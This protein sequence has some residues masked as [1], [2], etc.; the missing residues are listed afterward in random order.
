MTLRA[1]TAIPRAVIITFALLPLLAA[2]TQAPPPTPKRPVTDTY[3]GVKVV[4]DYRWL[5]NWNDPAVKD[6]VAAQNHY[7]RSY[8]DQLPGRDELRAKLKQINSAQSTSYRDV[9]YRGGTVFAIKSQPPKQQPFLVTFDSPDNA[10]SERVI[11]DPNK[12]DPSGGTSIDF[13]VPSLNGKQVAVA[14]S[15]GGSEKSDLHIFS[16]A[17]GAELPDVEPYVNGPTAG[18]GVAWKADGRG[19]YYTR[20]PRGNERPPADRDFYQQVWFHELGKPVEQDTYVLG[21]D[22]PRIAETQLHTSVDGAWVLVSTNN[23]DGGEQ[24]HFLIGASGQ[25]Q[26]ITHFNDMVRSA[27]LGEDGAVYL[28]SVRNAPR[29][30]I[31]RLSLANPQLA[32]AKEIVPES[33]A[34]IDQVV[35]TKSRLYVIDMVGGPSRVR[36]FDL[37]GKQ[38][39]A[40]RTLP[41]SA[42]YDVVPL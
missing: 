11:V 12:I 41:V 27:A 26:Q 20:Y 36:V 23:G 2:N 25:P 17:D 4:D 37:G 7:T 22:F 24:E 38:V 3:H 16:V 13:Y 29:G 35:P 1:F 28:R 30:K 9:I 40:I 18:G 32:N 21:R 19:F 15:K 39:G 6:W 5:E 8:L 42:V 14:I 34:V 31:L 10:A 33:D